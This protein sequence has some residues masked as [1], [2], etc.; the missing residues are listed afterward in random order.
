MS[1]YKRIFIVGH[2]GAGNALKEHVLSIVKAL[3]GNEHD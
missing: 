1:K 2:P 3:K